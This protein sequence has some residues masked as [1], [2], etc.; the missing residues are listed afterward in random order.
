VLYPTVLRNWCCL[1]DSRYSVLVG[2]WKGL[3]CRVG[4]ECKVGLCLA[5]GVV[6]ARNVAVAYE[7]LRANKYIP[8]GK[9][10]GA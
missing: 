7:V 2:F 1:S 8:G 3:A 4:K 6:V 9:A 10:A 5:A